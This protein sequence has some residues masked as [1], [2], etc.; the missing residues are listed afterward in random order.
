MTVKEY[1]VNVYAKIIYYVC[2]FTFILT[3]TMFISNAYITIIEYGLYTITSTG[4]L[5]L[6]T[7][8]LYGLYASMSGR[9]EFTIFQHTMFSIMFTLATCIIYMAS[10]LFLDIIL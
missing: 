5:G 3:C 7:V 1:S 10:V 2:V 9:P 6:L 8:F 4:A